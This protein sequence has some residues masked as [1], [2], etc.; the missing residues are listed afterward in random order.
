MGFKVNKTVNWFAYWKLGQCQRGSS[1]RYF[2]WNCNSNSSKTNSIAVDSNTYSFIDMRTSC[3]DMPTAR[4]EGSVAWTG[5]RCCLTLIEPL[6]MSRRSSGLSCCSSIQQVL[7][8][9]LRGFILLFCLLDS[10]RFDCLMVYSFG[11]RISSFI[12]Y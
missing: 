2:D 11:R 4:F 6:L 3:F 7:F 10:F 9:H 5:H 8:I 12:Q 1:L